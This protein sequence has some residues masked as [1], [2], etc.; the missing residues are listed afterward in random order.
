MQDSSLNEPPRGKLDFI[1]PRMTKRIRHARRGRLSGF[2]RRLRVWLPLLAVGI[3]AL[4]FLWPALLPTFRMEDIAKNI[5]DLVVDNLNYTGVDSKN[6]P[7]SIIA[8]QATKPSGLDGIYVLTKPEGEITLKNGVWIDSKADDGR[9]DKAKERLHLTGNVRIFH[10]R[11]Y[12]L[13]TP[14]IHINLKNSDAWGDKGV[15]LQGLIGTIEGK[16]FR[17]SESGSL[18]VISG[19]A[20]AILRLQSRPVSGKASLP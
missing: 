20:K 7:Y 19:P 4:L 3:L 13:T 1:R 2:I 11:G 14:E 8:A 5:P 9:Y 16:G 12:Q 18:V 10:S 15:L 17:F 6:Q